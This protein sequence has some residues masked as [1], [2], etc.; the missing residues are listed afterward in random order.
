[1]TLCEIHA[2]FTSSPLDDLTLPV[3]GSFLVVK[4]EIC[5]LDKE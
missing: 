5:C 3:D 2:H 4:D 1:M